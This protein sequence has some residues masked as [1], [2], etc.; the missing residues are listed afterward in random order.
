MKVSM[1]FFSTSIDDLN[2]YHDVSDPASS[3]EEYPL[4]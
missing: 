3:I 1:D 2:Y 4:T